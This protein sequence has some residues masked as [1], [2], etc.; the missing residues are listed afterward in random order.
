MAADQGI[1][2]FAILDGNDEFVRVSE[3]DFNIIKQ[4]K[5]EADRLNRENGTKNINNY[6][7]NGKEYKQVKRNKLGTFDFFVEGWLETSKKSG[8]YTKKKRRNKKHNRKTKRRT[9]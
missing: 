6:I 1:A 5:E 7:I 4:R 8:G 9:H 3:P 2:E